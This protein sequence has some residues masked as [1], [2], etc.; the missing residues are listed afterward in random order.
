MKRID[1]KQQQQDGIKNQ[2]KQNKSS[3]TPHIRDRIEA[4]IEFVRYVGFNLV[5]KLVLVLV[6][7]ECYVA[8]YEQWQKEYLFQHVDQ[9]FV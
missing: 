8:E 9:F 7:S 6:Y 2:T 4:P 1:C 3:Q 5:V